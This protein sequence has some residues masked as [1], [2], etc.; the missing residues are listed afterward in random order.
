[1]P[2]ILF[3]C[4]H[5]PGRSPSQRFRFEQYIDYL[6]QNGFKCKISYLLNEADDK[7][8]YSKGNIIRK[9][10]III[11][12]L[13]KRTFEI[14]IKQ[15]DIVFVQRE[16]IMIGTA[17][18]ERMFSKKSKLVYDFDDSL[19]IKS[20][21]PGNQAFSFLKNSGKIK[22]I[23]SSA[24]LVIAG[25]EYLAEFALR[26]NSNVIIIPT[27][28]D[29]SI[30]KV[31][32]KKIPEKICIGWSGSFS[33]IEHFEHSLPVLEKIKKKYNGMIWFKVIGDE[34]YKNENLG[35]QGI[36]W[37][38]KNEVNK[39]QEIDIGIMPLAENEWTK[40]KCG[41]KGLLYMSLGIPSVLSAVGVN[42]EIIQDGINGFLAQTEDEWVEKLSRLIESAELRKAIGLKGV[43]TVFFKYSVISNRE[44]YLNSLRSLL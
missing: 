10:I 22:N 44:I 30:Y 20:V 19:W 28:V 24:D 26:Y 3:V 5:R 6:E 42:K 40:G 2:S 14:L 36:P 37:E 21:S 13:I 38:R 31:K 17:F 4:L 34:N 12:S 41:L 9:S 25:N 33:T 7:I 23:V 43:Q 11:K 1:M 8:F 16:C 32:E 35:I 18:F 39:L 29:T 15:A 27:T